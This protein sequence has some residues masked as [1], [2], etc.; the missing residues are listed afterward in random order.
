MD[1]LRCSFC[2]KRHD[3][4]ERLI[5]G[6]AVHICN[7]C[8]TLCVQALADTPAAPPGPQQI[9]VRMPDGTVHGCAQETGWAS[10]AHESGTYEW[11]SARGFI[12]ANTAQRVVV[13]RQRG[14][15]PGACFG[16][17]FPPNTAVTEERARAEIER[18]R[19][20]DG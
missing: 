2:G 17:A 5:A 12:R 18:Y 16:A 7:E 8:V 19:R 3:E 6:P 13:V 9:L 1:G 11:C 4:V 10:L 14:E 15:E 20:S